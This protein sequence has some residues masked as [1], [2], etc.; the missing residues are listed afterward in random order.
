MSKSLAWI[1]TAVLS[2]P[3]GPPPGGIVSN[4]LGVSVDKALSGSHP[5]VSE[6]S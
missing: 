2:Q 4:L 3:N 5:R 6:V 1:V